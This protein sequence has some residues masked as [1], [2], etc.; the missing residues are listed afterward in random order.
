MTQLSLPVAKA[1]K[2]W[3]LLFPKGTPH[4][5]AAARFMEKHGH[6]PAKVWQDDSNVFAGPAPAREEI[7][8]L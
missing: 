5:A 3:W 6:E 4:E 8:A 7:K 1:A 2:P